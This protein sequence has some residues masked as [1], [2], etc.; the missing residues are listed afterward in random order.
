MG[1]VLAALTLGGCGSKTIAIDEQ[2]KPSPTPALELPRGVLF[3]T[4]TERQLVLLGCETSR[5]WATD[6]ATCVAPLPKDAPLTPISAE[7]EPEPL[8]DPEPARCVAPAYADRGAAWPSSYVAMWPP[9]RSEEL[10]EASHEADHWP[11]YNQERVRAEQRALVV[12]LALAGGVA[13]ADLPALLES[14]GYRDLDADL[15]GDGVLDG[16]WS[17]TVYS[18]KGEFFQSAVVAQMSDSP[19]PPRALFKEVPGRGLELLA[20]IDLDRD[21]RSELVLGSNDLKGAGGALV[22]YQHGEL[23]VISSFF[24]AA[25]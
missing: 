21:G 25:Q 16:L 19:G 12:E 17:L 5:G 13:A 9:E 23:V 24:C 8:P 7:H 10:V 1:L 15:D 22:R 14:R 20:A 2:V 6:H 18:P 4:S 3:M 11:T